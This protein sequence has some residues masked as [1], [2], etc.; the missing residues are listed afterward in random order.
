[1][2]DISGF[3]KG[4]YIELHFLAKIAVH[5]NIIKFANIASIFAV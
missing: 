5:L 2:H 4:I 1:M 3:S